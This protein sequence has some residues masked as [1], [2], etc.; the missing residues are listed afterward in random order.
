MA[1]CATTAATTRR[2]VTARA[3]RRAF[4]EIPADQKWHLTPAK[5]RPH[6]VSLFFGLKPKLFYLEQRQLKSPTKS[7]RICYL[8]GFDFSFL[9]SGLKHIDLL[10][11][12]ILL[13]HLPKS[14]MRHKADF[15]PAP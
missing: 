10:D 13:Q 5:V 2:A 8:E 1:G 3:V 15:Q 9:P 12:G 6:S 4:T 11:K 7:C 14:L